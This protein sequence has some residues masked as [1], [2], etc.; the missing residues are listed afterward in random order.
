M[1]DAA[2]RRD[3]AIRFERRLREWMRLGLEIERDEAALERFGWRRDGDPPRVGPRDS[4]RVAR[5]KERIL[6][7]RRRREEI[8]ASLAEIG[9]EIADEAT[10]EVLLPGGPAAGDRLSWRPGEPTVRWWRPGGDRRGER[11]PLAGAEGDEHE[12]ELH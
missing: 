1:Q 9:A 3:L 5:L 8:R 4:R 10:L 2:A 6:E 7:G 12:V 11:I